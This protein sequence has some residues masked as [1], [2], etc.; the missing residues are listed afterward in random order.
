MPSRFLY[1]E[2]EGYEPSLPTNLPSLKP[3]EVNREKP[4]DLDLLIKANYN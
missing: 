2:L 4:F 1:N 3:D